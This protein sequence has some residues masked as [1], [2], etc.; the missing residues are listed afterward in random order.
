MRQQNIANVLITAVNIP[1]ALLRL[2]VDDDDECEE[3]GSF[4][5]DMGC[6]VEVDEDD[7]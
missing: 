5:F 6:I 1:C 3:D 4:E 7:I 2:F